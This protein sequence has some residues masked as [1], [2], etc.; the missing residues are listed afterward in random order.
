MKLNIAR[1]AFLA[2]G[3]AITGC[4]IAQAQDGDIS[5]RVER[6]WEDGF[7]LNNGTQT[8]KVDSYGVCGDNTARHI[9]IGDLVNV[10]G[11]F[12][13]GDFDAFSI[14]TADGENVCS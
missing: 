2:V 6:V 4:T 3:V 13:W 14:T 8:I 11:E 10:T 7:R 1:F 12:D 9:N 5:G